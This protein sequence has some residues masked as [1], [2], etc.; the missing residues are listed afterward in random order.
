MADGHWWGG[1]QAPSNE[2]PEGR[3]KR[4]QKVF[5]STIAAE[6]LR[7]VRGLAIKNARDGVMNNVIQDLTAIMIFYAAATLGGNDV[8]PYIYNA[9]LK[10]RINTVCTP[11]NGEEEVLRLQEYIPTL[12][13]IA[14]HELV[15]IGGPYDHDSLPTITRLYPH[16]FGLFETYVYSPIYRIRLII[17]LYDPTREATIIDG[18]GEVIAAV[19]PGGN[20]EPLAIQVVPYPSAVHNLTILIDWVDGAAEAAAVEQVV[21]ETQL[22]RHLE[23]EQLACRL[24]D[25]NSHTLVETYDPVTCQWYPNEFYNPVTDEIII[26]K[27]N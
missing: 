24:A 11:L 16:Y 12:T 25:S 22:D 1:D 23:D 2:L 9:E 6:I 7:R 14:L 10:K 21:L 4:R 8:A 5:V 26:P 15:V 13:R 19:N 17:N 3:C 20:W 27:S 18:L